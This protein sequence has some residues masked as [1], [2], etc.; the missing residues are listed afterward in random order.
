MGNALARLHADDEGATAT[1][2]IIILV[3]VVAATVVLWKQFGKMI[4][5]KF[6]GARDK[7]EHNL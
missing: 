6:Q 5:S 2:Y 1:E 4:S 3:L 7:I